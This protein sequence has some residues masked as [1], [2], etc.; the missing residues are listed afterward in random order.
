MSAD[1]ADWQMCMSSDA[2]VKLPRDETAISAR[3]CFS[4]AFDVRLMSV[5]MAGIDAEETMLMIGCKV[6]LAPLIASMWI[7]RGT[8]AW[9]RA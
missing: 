3:N 4:E 5:L 2:A 1:S 6:F 7:D 8:T 9:V